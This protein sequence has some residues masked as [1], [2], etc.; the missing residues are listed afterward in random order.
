M[1]LKITTERRG[2]MRPPQTEARLEGTNFRSI[3]PNA[4]EAKANLADTVLRVLNTQSGPTIIIAGEHL[5]GLIWSES[6]DWRFNVVDLLGLDK[7]ECSAMPT[8]GKATYV[9]GSE[10]CDTRQEAER[11]LRKRLAATMDDPSIILDDDDRAEWQKARNRQDVVAATMDRLELDW[12]S[13]SHVVDGLWC[14]DF[15]LGQCTEIPPDEKNGYGRS[16][17]R[18][19]PL[20]HGSDGHRRCERHHR[21][22]NTF[23]TGS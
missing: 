18:S 4:T 19:P 16:S 14:W 21:L 15:K 7:P 11:R 6:G 13:A 3:A 2:Y 23:M 12:T 1:S 22:F 9:H 17:W 20:T 5:I 10:S 8:I